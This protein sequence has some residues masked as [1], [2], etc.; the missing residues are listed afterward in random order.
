MISEDFG[1]ASMHRK[2]YYAPEGI[3][4]PMKI[5]Q[6]DLQVCNKL[7]YIHRETLSMVPHLELYDFV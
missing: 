7:C 4:T 5:D 6:T 2:I 3:N 1:L